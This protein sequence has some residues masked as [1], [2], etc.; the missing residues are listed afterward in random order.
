MFRA[1]TDNGGR[2]GKQRTQ[3]VAGATKPGAD[4]D[5]QTKQRDRCLCHHMYT[6]FSMQLGTTVSVRAAG[7]DSGPYWCIAAG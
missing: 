2:G 3:T 1:Q 7:A 4:A 6:L 5:T